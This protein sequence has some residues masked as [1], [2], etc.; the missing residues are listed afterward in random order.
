MEIS[1][2]LGTRLY[3]MYLTTLNNVPFVIIHLFLKYKKM[4]SE[5]I[6]RNVNRLLAEPYGILSD[7]IQ[8]GEIATSFSKSSLLLHHLS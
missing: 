5:Q 4:L 2:P 1:S 3:I 8:Y 7:L 6:Y